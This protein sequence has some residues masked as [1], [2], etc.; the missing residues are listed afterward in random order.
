M[1]SQNIESTGNK[2]NKNI[3]MNVS[4]NG[5]GN[6]GSGND[7]KSV[8]LQKYKSLSS[9]MS[10]SLNRRNNHSQL[11]KFNNKTNSK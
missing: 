7:R 2:T 5:N 9:H 6:G 1:E 4:G 8:F 11:Y 3:N 10:N